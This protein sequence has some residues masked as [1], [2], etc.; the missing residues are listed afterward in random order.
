MAGDLA[1]TGPGVPTS[2]RMS[3][4]AKIVSGA[5]GAE[6]TGVDLRDAEIEDGPESPNAADE[7]HT[8]GDRPT[9][10]RIAA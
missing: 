2:D 8:D 1:P 10:D 6:L 7:W 5:L 3:L 4:Q 9:S